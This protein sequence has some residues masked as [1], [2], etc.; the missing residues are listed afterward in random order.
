MKIEGVDHLWNTS[1]SVTHAEQ[2]RP[3]QLM[4]IQHFITIG[5]MDQ[6]KGSTPPVRLKRV[7]L[8]CNRSQ[9]TDIRGNS[10]VLSFPQVNCYLSQNAKDNF[11]TTYTPQFTQSIFAVDFAAP[12]LCLARICKMRRYL[13]INAI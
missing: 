9:G 13:P 10:Q 2:H 1:H 11:F 12:I 6:Y 7:Y 5:K 4:Y 8:G 3:I